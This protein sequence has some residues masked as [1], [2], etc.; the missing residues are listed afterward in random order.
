MFHFSHYDHSSL[1]CHRT[2]FCVCTTMLPLQPATQSAHGG[3]LM[4]GWKGGGASWYG[5]LRQWVFALVPLSTSTALLLRWLLSTT[6]HTARALLHA[7]AQFL[8]SKTWELLAAFCTRQ[9]VWLVPHDISCTHQHH[10]HM[11]PV[12][13]SSYNTLSCHITSCRRH[14]LKEHFR[15][16]RPVVEGRSVLHSCA[17]S[18][19]AVRE[20]GRGLGVFLS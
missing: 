2:A 14:H 7:H 13:F 15:S 4:G 19:V 11:R 10:L 12:L 1:S 9:A 18:R 20:G 6:V 5:F 3:V 8:C 16:S 17:A